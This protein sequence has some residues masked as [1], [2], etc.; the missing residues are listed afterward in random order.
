[1]SDVVSRLAAANPVPTG[2]PV[3]EPA[4]LPAR[5]IA[6]AAAL[7]A[8][9]AVPT[10]AFAAR[11][12]DLLGLSNQ[13]T[14]VATSSLPLSQDSKLNEAMGSLG[15]P[16]TL[17]QLGTV[18]GVDF[19]AARTPDGRYC[20]AIEKDGV[21]G[22]V[23]CD[24]AGTFPSPADPVWIFPPYEGFNGYAADGVAAVEGLDA[25]GQVVVSVPVSGNLFAA[26]A[27]DYRSVTTVAAFDDQGTQ[28]WTRQ[29]P[30]R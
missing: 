9:V 3:R 25:S 7:A 18:N 6:V 23:G 2:A 19:Y 28:V 16:S 1:M 14:P 26:P 11:L 15:F 21:R 27:A 13:G 8:A 29:L 17:R 5:R 30:N 24:L 20:F 10:V 22:G 4:P 12:G